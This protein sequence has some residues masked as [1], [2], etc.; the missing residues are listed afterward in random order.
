MNHYINLNWQSHL[1][2]F[3][4]KIQLKIGCDI[5]KKISQQDMYNQIIS[6]LLYY[7]LNDCLDK[8]FII[9]LELDLHVKTSVLFHITIPKPLRNKGLGSAIVVELEK[10]L[11]CLDINYLSLPAEHHSTA[12]WLKMGYKFKFL[13]ERA[14]YEK[15]SQHDYP[16][17]AFELEKT[18]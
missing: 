10:F 7:N 5:Q 6:V 15:H 3:I 1:K 2:N 16:H 17:L 13:K 4:H 11:M 12:F 8:E 14:F 9:D 18:L